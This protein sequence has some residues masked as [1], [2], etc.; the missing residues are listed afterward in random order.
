MSRVCWVWLFYH[1]AS[2][3]QPA[4]TR[5][6]PNVGSMLVLSLRC[7]PN[8]EP[9]LGERLVFVVIYYQETIPQC[10]LA[11]TCGGRLNICQPPMHS[12]SI[13]HASEAMPHFPEKILLTL[14]SSWF[15]FHNRVR[16]GGWQYF[17]KRG[18]DISWGA[19]LC[20]KAN[21]QYICLLHK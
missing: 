10:L 4:N 3:V 5:R 9:A 15:V 21:R 14:A 1:P 8:I 18:G 13:C 6:S 17:W 19:H 7:W 2:D 11:D 16:S 20:R 12:L